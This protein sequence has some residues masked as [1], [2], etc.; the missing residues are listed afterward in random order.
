MPKLSAHQSLK[1][2]KM[3]LLGDSGAGKT[4]A[5]ASLADSGYNVRILDL[6]NGADVLSNLLRDPKSMYKKEALGLVDCVTLTDPMSNINGKLVPKKATVWQ[7]AVG[8]LND[9]KDGEQNYGPISTWTDRDVL[10]IDSL[11][12][13]ANAAMNFVLAMNARLGQQPHQSDWYQGQQMLESLLQMLYDESI[14]CNVIV[15][16]HV[17]YIG[18]DN[19]PQHGY[20]SSL[21]KAL[22]P[23]IGRYFNTV[24][25]AKTQGSGA[26]LKRQIIT[27]SVPMIELKNTAPL[28]IKPSYPLETGLADIFKDLRSVT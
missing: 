13:L 9:W 5:L 28:R 14:K 21:G 1:T 24:L 12:F 20:P 26:S 25:L 6:D 11:S 3:I 27:N 7:R 18:E 10:V 17:T 2:T 19:G 4:G 16:A 23:K 15:I 22:G 8:M